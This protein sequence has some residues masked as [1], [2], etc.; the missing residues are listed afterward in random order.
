MIRSGSGHRARRTCRSIVNF[1]KALAAS[2]SASR[3]VI[4]ECGD[5]R[6]IW[7]PSW[8]SHRKR[9][10]SRGSDSIFTV[11]CGSSLAAKCGS[12]AMFALCRDRGHSAMAKKSP[13][14]AECGARFIVNMGGVTVGFPTVRFTR[15]S[16]KPLGDCHTGEEE[17][18]A[19]CKP[20]FEAKVLLGN[21]RL[22]RPRVASWNLLCM[23]H[24]PPA[25]QMQYMVALTKDRP[26]HAT[27]AIALIEYA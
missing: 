8:T 16:E 19:G 27:Y 6:W 3:R 18:E 22:W 10:S 2:D 7:S 12:S 21:L 17:E 24:R 20:E 26:S 14:G 4:Y 9:C 5:L 13:R 15:E 23:H 25:Q 11:K 1:S